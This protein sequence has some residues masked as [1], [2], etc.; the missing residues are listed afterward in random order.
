MGVGAGLQESYDY[1]YHQVDYRQGYASAGDQPNSVELLPQ[2]DKDQIDQDHADADH[3]DDWRQEVHDLE[4]YLLSGVRQLVADRAEVLHK[5]IP[6]HGGSPPKTRLA[7]SQPQLWGSES[8]PG[9]SKKGRRACHSPNRDSGGQ[10]GQKEGGGFAASRFPPS[11]PG[12]RS[13]ENSVSVG[14]CSPA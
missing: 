6:R 11:D 4:D 12:R 5:T 10:P 3:I 14:L 1:R 7:P 9:P 8:L 13:E 2:R